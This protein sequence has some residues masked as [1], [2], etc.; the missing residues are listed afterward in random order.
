MILICRFDWTLLTIDCAWAG[1]GACELAEG[2]FRLALLPRDSLLRN[3]L[4]SIGSAAGLGLPAEVMGAL[5]SYGNG[6]RRRSLMW[7]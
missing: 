3:M 6:V 7:V 5:I 4:A 1:V 2:G